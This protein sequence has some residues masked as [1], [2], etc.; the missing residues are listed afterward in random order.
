MT[1]T[2]SDTSCLNSELLFQLQRFAKRSSCWKVF[3]SSGGFRL[4]DSSVL[5]PDASLVGLER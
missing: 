1:P 3:D 4:A 2:G 5:S